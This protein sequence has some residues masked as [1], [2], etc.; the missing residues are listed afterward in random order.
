MERDSCGV[1]AN[2]AGERDRRDTGAG[3]DA[4]NGKVIAGHVRFW[5]RDADRSLDRMAKP[6]FRPTDTA[7]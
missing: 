4:R 7:Q 1:K 3:S 6:L 2:A 5:L